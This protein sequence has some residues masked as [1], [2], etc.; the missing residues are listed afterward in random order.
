MN[1][2]ASIQGINLENLPPVT[3][4]HVDLDN[5]HSNQ[6]LSYEQHGTFREDANMDDSQ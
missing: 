3:R 2:L 6:N 1:T 4:M 5:S